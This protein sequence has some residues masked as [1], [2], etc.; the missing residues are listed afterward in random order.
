MI[1]ILVFL[2]TTHFYVFVIDK[3]GLFGKYKSKYNDKMQKDILF[4]KPFYA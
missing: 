3:D 1:T 2:I 4:V